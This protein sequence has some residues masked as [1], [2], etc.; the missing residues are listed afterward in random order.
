MK[1]GDARWRGFPVLRALHDQWWRA[2][3]GRLGEST[4][5]FSRDWNQLLEDA[6]LVSAEHRAEAERDAHQLAAAEWVRLRAPRLRPHLIERIL[7]P[8]EAEAALAALFG[9]PTASGAAAA[10]L[11]ALPWEP[12]LAFVRDTRVGI[13]VEDLLAMNRFLAEGGRVRPVVPI[14]ERSLQIFGD[15]KRLDA[16]LVS[17]PFRSGRVT[18]ETLRCALVAEPLG[19][20]RGPDPAGPV[21][22]LENAATWD[23]YSRWNERERRFSAVVYGKGLVFADAVGRLVDI[24]QEIGGVRRVE[25]FGDLDPPGLEIPFRASRR[26]QANGLPAVTPHRWSYRRLLDVGAG[27]EGVWEGDPVS[28]QALAWLGEEGE[29]ARRLFACGRRLAQEHVGWEVLATEPQ[30]AVDG[31]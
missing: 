17:A 24:F 26:A 9:D 25:Y 4:R 10:D 6:G 29:A 11:A 7:I 1:D 12:E 3:G 14:K 18:L 5:P 2:R 20:R 30:A 21:L 19:W 15:E 23:S 22:V 8:V 13:A 28:E 16:L 27:R 31:C